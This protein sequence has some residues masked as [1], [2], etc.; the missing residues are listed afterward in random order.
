MTLAY[1][2]KLAGLFSKE[3]KKTLSNLIFYVT[4]PASL[5]SGF[6]DAKVNIYYIVAILTG[7]G[8]NTVM[9]IAGQI[10]S[11]NKSRELQAIYAVNASGYNLSLIHI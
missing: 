3:D 5:I 1:I 4:L 8:V 2:L 6:T 11:R 7:F 10:A 9:V